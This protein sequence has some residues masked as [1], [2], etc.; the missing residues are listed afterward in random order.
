MD[1]DL[2]KTSGIVGRACFVLH[3]SESNALSERAVGV[4]LKVGMLKN[5]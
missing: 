3:K 4:H 1:W 5:K 2:N